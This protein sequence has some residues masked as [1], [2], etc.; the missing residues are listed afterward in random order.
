MT[1]AD[2][3]AS[4][5]LLLNTKKI[6]HRLL[7]WFP[8]SRSEVV[9]VSTPAA[10]AAS[11]LDNPDAHFRHVHSVSGFAD[12]SLEEELFQ[13]CCQFGVE[14][15]L[16]TGEREVLPAARLRERLGLPGIDV[17]TATA[18]RDKFVM[19]SILADAGL[20][21][22]PMRRVDSVAALRDFAAEV[23]YPAV[24]KPLD[25][26]GSA[27]IQVLSDAD[28]LEAVIGGLDAAVWCAPML[29]EAW[30]AGD[31]YQVNGLM[32]DGVVVLGQ[33]CYNPYSGWL[34]VAFH[35]PNMNG[36]L[37]E[38]DPLAARLRAATT[39]VLAA[40]PTVPGVSAF[41]AEF[42][43]T[44]DDQLVLNEIACRAGGGAIVDTHEAVLGVNLHGAGLLGQAGR[45]VP[46]HDAPTMPRQGFAHFPPA[47]G[48]L[49]E[50][51][52]RCPLPNVLTYSVSGECGRAYHGAES[53]GPTVAKMTFTLS[54]SDVRAELRQIEQ[55]W[56]RNTVWENRTSGVPNG[57]AWLLQPTRNAKNR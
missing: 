37:P 2:S 9:L 42:F 47:C 57:A 56:E 10:L 45:R 36:M 18:F 13:L 35:V 50:I 38:T 34:S 44:P 52:V 26:G 54:T 48:V 28:D 19:K 24:V 41:H 27:G 33:P 6:V 17:S 4:S 7:D 40:L 20:P 31:F 29:A 21:V 11:G 39:Q 51:P 55:W 12:P 46:L 53:L 23:G 8:D 25:R 49:R 32:D 43:H 3:G 22:A 16:S 5:F 15:I 1:A 14:R 30:I